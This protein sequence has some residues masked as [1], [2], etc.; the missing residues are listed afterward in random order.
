MLDEVIPARLPFI[1]FFP[2]VAL[3]ALLCV[4]WPAV[5]VLL[6]SAIVGVWWGQPSEGSLVAFRFWASSLFLILGG[7]VVGL[8]NYLTV[9]LDRLKRQDEQ[10]ALIN[11]ELKHRIKNLFSITNSICQQTIKSGAPAEQMAKAASGR[12][13]A[14]ASAQDLLST[15]AS[16]GAELRSLVDALVT[17][18]SPDRS[19]LQITGGAAKLPAEFTTS[20]A[21]I[22]HELATNALKY[23]AWLAETGVVL[24]EWSVGSDRNLKFRWRERDGLNIAPPLREGL[25]TALI[26][27]GLNGAKVQHDLKA[28]GLD[29]RIEITIA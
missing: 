5:L 20:F 7:G 10:L 14:I 11:R 27:R 21:L 12:I 13:L 26:K 25:G 16:E 29:C 22:L 9:L 24:I 3:A 23:G 17:P 19:R 18:V 6:L 4:L 1:T 8:V 2:A 28:D 15:T